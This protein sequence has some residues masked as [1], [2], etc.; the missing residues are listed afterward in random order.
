MREGIFVVAEI[1]GF[2]RALGHAIPRVKKQ[3]DLLFPFESGQA[4]HLHSG[5]WQLEA[6][7]LL[8]HFQ[9]EISPTARV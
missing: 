4:N 8:S 5:V 3:H 6:W 2:T 7:C 9:H 1:D